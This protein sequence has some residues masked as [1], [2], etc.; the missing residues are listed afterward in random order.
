MERDLKQILEENREILNDMLSRNYN[1]KDILK[2]SEKVD[3]LVLS[4]MKHQ[5]N[6][7]YNS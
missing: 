7:K 1:S 6:K 4:L 3:K 2:Q 5:I